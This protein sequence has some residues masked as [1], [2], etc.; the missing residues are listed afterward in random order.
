MSKRINVNPDHYKGAVRS[1]AEDVVQAARR[2]ELASKRTE[3]RRWLA[4]RT[5]AGVR[6]K[7]AESAAETEG[8][9]EHPRPRISSSP[10]GPSAQSTSTKK[11]S[12]KK[13]RK[14]ANRKAA[15]RT[16]TSKAAGESRTEAGSKKKSSR[17]KAD[18]GS[19]TRRKKL[20]KK[21]K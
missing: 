13:K 19:T 21:K 7:A 9:V 18:G 3:M 10:P 1:Q 20:S 17:K 5:R 15:G 8:S 6:G 12:K 11:S 16:A 14:S 2:R 4:Q